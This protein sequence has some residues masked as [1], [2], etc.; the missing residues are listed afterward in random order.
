MEHYTMSLANR[1]VRKQ[2]LA[3]QA[4]RDRFLRNIRRRRFGFELLEDRTLL[5]TVTWDGGAGTLNFG[6]ALNWDNDV[7]PSPANDYV[8]PLLGGTPTI[9][10][11]S[12]TSVR[13]IQSTERVS[14]SP[15]NSAH[16]ISL[17][18]DS[19]LSA[20]LDISSG[21]LNL[22]PGSVLTVGGN[23]TWTGNAT[24]AGLAT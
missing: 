19:S 12:T 1:K 10:I 5:A 2:L 22:G 23:S 20:G 3:R 15:A 18:S 9:L 24:I 16:T 21:T 6:D 11:Q 13:S 14:I 17:A 4:N 7:P 8:I